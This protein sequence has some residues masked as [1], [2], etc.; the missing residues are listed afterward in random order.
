[1][2]LLPAATAAV[3]LPV[4]CLATAGALALA[5]AVCGAGPTRPAV[6]LPRQRSAPSPRE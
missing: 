5:A 2:Y 4:L 3:P 1:V 6:R